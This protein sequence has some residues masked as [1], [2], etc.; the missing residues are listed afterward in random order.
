MKTIKIIT[1]LCFLSI[2]VSQNNKNHSVFVKAQY[3]P[4]IG[5]NYKLTNNISV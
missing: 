2:G 5:I 3:V 4:S 1:L